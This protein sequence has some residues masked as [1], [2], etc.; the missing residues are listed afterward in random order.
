MYDVSVEDP[1]ANSSIFVLPII[2]APASSNFLITV[3]SY[4]GVKFS[5]ILEAHV[6]LTPF[7][8]ILSFIAI[9]TPPS[10]PISSPLSNLCCSFSALSYAISLVKVIY[11]ST[12]GSTS[13]ILE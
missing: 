4:I 3:A 7:V 5:S 10:T 6:V 9:G 12:L 8:Q 2:I 13:S 11:A 1:I